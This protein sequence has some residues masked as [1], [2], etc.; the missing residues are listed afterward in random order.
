[1]K[2]ENN[3]KR[4]GERETDRPTYRQKKIGYIYICHRFKKKIKKQQ[5]QNKKAKRNQNFYLQ[6]LKKKQQKHS[7]Q[8][9]QQKLD[10][11]VEN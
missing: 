7:L 3:N 6:S 11:C 8:K 1:M 4:Q 2:W 9:K 10:Y 5:Q